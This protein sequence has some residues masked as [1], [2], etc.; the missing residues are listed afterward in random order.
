MIIYIK[1][2]VCNRCI[3]A[4]KHIFEQEQIHPKSV[5]LGEV[6]IDGGIEDEKWNIVHTQLQHSGF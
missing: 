1:N 6:E 4:V 2:M 5:Q 3:A